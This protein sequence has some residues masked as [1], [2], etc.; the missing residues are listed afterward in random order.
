MPFLCFCVFV[1]VKEG[2]GSATPDYYVWGSECKNVGVAF[3]GCGYQL[4]EWAWPR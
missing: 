4:N 1:C 3:G 2:K